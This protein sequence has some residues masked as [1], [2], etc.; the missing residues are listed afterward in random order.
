MGEETSKS[1]A[2]I[3]VIMFWSSGGGKELAGGTMEGKIETEE[4]SKTLR[5]KRS[6]SRG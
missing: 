4:K 5:P 2:F 6:H 1:L 3:N